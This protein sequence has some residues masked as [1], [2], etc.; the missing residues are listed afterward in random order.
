M[1]GPRT[2]ANPLLAAALA[3]P[4][5][6][7]TAALAQS[8]PDQGI[9]ALKYLD[10]R[11]WQPGADRMTVRSPSMYVLAPFAGQWTVEGSLVYDAMSGASPLYFN[12]LSGASGLGV[13]DYR[14]AGDVKVTRYFDRYS[15]GVGGAYSHERD[16]IS[17]AGSLD[18]RWWT[19][20]KNVTLDFGFAGDA[21]YIHPSAR[22]LDNGRRD[23][24][25]FLAGVTVNL[26]PLDLVQ[27]TI[28]YSTGHGYYSDPYKPLDTRPGERRVFAW[29]TRYNHYFAQPDATLQLGYRYLGDSF[30]GESHAFDVAWAQALPGSVTLT[31]SLRY[32]TQSAADFWFGPPY[33][34]GFVVG[35]NFTADTRLSAFG[36]FTAGLGVVKALAD[37]W[38]VDLRFD[39]YRQRAG[40]RAFGTG[41]EGI[42]PFS[43]R[44]IAA[45]VSRAF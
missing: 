5:I 43:A 17:R 39:F 19:A 26:S 12:T 30:G 13:T 14:T 18:V 27:S 9:F 24:L 1:A 41:S 11:D 36:A 23:T 2:R 6:V 33:P 16:Y 38:T 21:D 35:Q 3:L 8:M 44:W 45:G 34:Q 37:G 7:P 29:Q 31:P 15:I 25:D 10:Y 20:D 40:W 32:Y 4:G 22:E 28:T 42:E